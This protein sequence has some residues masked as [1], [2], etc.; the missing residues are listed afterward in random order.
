MNIVDNAS[1]TMI[2]LCIC[3]TVSTCYTESLH[4]ICISVNFE[5]SGINIKDLRIMMNVCF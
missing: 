1:I 4:T 2:I 3:Y 5:S